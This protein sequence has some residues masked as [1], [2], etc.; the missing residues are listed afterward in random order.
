MS[1]VDDIF[2]AAQSLDP[3]DRW[4]LVHRICDSLPDEAWGIFDEAEISLLDQ[5]LADVESGK[6]ETI[7]WPEAR[8]QIYARLKRDG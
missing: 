7:P 3:A 4:A 1:T 5:R 2:N 6:V 8:R